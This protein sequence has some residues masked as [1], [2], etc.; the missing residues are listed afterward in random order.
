MK[1]LVLGSLIGAAALAAS[2]AHAQ[3]ATLKSGEA[4]YKETCAACHATGLLKAPKLGDKKNWAP[5]LKEPQATLTADGW[6]GVRD[7]PA[8]GGNPNLTLEEFARAAGAKWQDPDAAMIKRIQAEEKKALD[9]KAK[10]KGK[11]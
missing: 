10:E 11:K 1:H 4:V 7:M 8:K 2:V 6:E 5:L 3:T 9:K